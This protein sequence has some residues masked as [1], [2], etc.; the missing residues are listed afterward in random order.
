MALGGYK[1]FPAFDAPRDKKRCNYT[2]NLEHRSRDDNI[3]MEKTKV[4]GVVGE[5]VDAIAQA[6]RGPQ[7]RQ[8]PAPGRRVVGRRRGRVGC[9]RG[10]CLGL[11]QRRHGH[12]DEEERG[13]EERCA[14]IGMLTSAHRRVA[15]VRCCGFDDS[16]RAAASP[17]N[18]NHAA[19]VVCT[20]MRSKLDRRP[21]GDIFESG[22]DGEHGEEERSGAR[23]DTIMLCGSGAALFVGCGR[24]GSIRGALGRRSPGRGEGFVFTAGFF[25]CGCGGRRLFGG[26]RARGLGLG[27]RGRTLGPP[28]TSSLMVGAERRCLCRSQ[29]GGAGVFFFSCGAAGGPWTEP[30]TVPVVFSSFFFRAAAG[31]LGQSQAEHLRVPSQASRSATQVPRRPSDGATDG[32]SDSDS[33]AS[34]E[35]AERRCFGL[36]RLW[37]GGRD[38]A[39][40]TTHAL[41]RTTARRTPARAGARAIIMYTRSRQPA[42]PSLIR[43]PP[44]LGL[45]QLCARCAL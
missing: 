37:G 19:F 29:L 24:A 36:E 2:T 9:C 4:A 17:I 31:P 25:R 32:D 18:G 41:A 43:S 14:S 15:F 40:T 42:A 33:D 12:G 38:C 11:R 16:E 6:G 45:D 27:L 8:A 7:A 13:Q 22:G 44:G 5:T 30:G 21:A 26:G 39:S 23:E 34:G 28:S 35:A 1:R 10:V 20:C 3:F